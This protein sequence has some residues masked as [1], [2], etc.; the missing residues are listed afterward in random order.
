MEG[1]LPC[2]SISSREY[3]PVSVVARMI[4]RNFK[5]FCLSISKLFNAIFSPILLVAFHFHPNTFFHF[6]RS[7]FICIQTHYYPLGRE[8]YRL[9]LFWSKKILWI[10]KDYVGM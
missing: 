1:T 5:H 4:G 7:I 6:P 3:C 8:H 10:L 9:I 2:L